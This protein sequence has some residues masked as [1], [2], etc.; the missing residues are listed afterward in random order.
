MITLANK[1]WN[2]SFEKFTTKV[3][4]LVKDKLSC[5]DNS[6]SEHKIVC[7]LESVVYNI[8][9]DVERLE[10]FVVPNTQFGEFEHSTFSESLDD[11]VE[12]SWQQQLPQLPIQHTQNPQ[13]QQHNLVIL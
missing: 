3:D 4:R 9:M 5:D 8:Q 6:L 13:K 12:A 10:T 1:N 2:K 7:P 11:D